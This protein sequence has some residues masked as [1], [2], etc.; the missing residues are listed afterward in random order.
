MSVYQKMYD[1]SYSNH[2][3]PKRGRYTTAE[4]LAAQYDMEAYSTLVLAASQGDDIY[5]S[6]RDFVLYHLFQPASELHPL[7]R[8]ILIKTPSAFS[9]FSIAT[10]GRARASGRANISPQSCCL[11]VILLRITQL[12]HLR[13]IKFTCIYAGNF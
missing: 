3:D 6:A 10:W 2:T 9:F 7:S 8:P 12:S 1:E 13:S 11:Y 4:L 5:D